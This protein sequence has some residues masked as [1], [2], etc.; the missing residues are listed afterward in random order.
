[1]A[2]N[3]AHASIQPGPNAPSLHPAFGL[4]T[5]RSLPDDSLSVLLAIGNIPRT[6]KYIPSSHTTISTVYTYPPA[7]PLPSTGPVDPFSLNHGPVTIFPGAPTLIPLPSSSN[8]FSSKS[9][10]TITPHFS[11]THFPASAPTANSPTG[12]TSSISAPALVYR[13]VASPHA[14]EPAVTPGSAPTQSIEGPTPPT[15]TR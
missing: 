15:S 2:D 7:Y 12:S 8:L 14:S 4:D 11:S 13:D 5:L 10:N 3:A 9:T 1:M 6:E